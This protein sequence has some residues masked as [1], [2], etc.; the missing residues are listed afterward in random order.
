MGKILLDEGLIGGVEE[1][2]G[3]AGVGPGDPA[4]Q[5]I[6]AVGR[7]GGIVRG[8]QIDQIGLQTILRQGKKLVFRA[9]GQMHDFPP[10]HDVRVHIGGI[11]RLHDQRA[12]FPVEQIQNIAQLVA[13]AAGDEDLI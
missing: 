12:V 10:G 2:Q 5:L 7:A 3:A 6:P 11:G 9:G 4:G 8:T 1:N 13:G